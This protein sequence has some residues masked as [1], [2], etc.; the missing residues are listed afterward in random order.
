MGRGRG[1]TPAET[2]QKWEKNGENG[3][4]MG[5]WKHSCAQLWYQYHRAQC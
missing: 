1:A 5:L 3:M 2:G 4:G